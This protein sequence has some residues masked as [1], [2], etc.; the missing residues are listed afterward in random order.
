MHAIQPVLLTIEA[1][2]H[3]LFEEHDV[4]AIQGSLVDIQDVVRVDTPGAKRAVAE[5]IRRHSPT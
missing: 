1:D 3:A 5:L 2:L 4:S